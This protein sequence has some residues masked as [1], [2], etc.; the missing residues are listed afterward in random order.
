MFE[1]KG[2]QRLHA[3]CSHLDQKGKGSVETEQDRKLGNLLGDNSG[4]L[5]ILRQNDD[6]LGN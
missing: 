3:L 2:L 6:P 4:M 1:D 5:I